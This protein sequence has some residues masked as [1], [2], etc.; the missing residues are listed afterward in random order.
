MSRVKPFTVEGERV[1]T[2]QVAA[3]LSVVVVV[4]MTTAVMA[5]DGGEEYDSFMVHSVVSNRSRSLGMRV[6]S[7]VL[8]S[9][10]DRGDFVGSLVGDLDGELLLESENELDGIEAVEAEVFVEVRGVGD[11]GGVDLVELFDDLDHALGDLLRRERGRGAEEPVARSADGRERRSESR[12]RRARGEANEADERHGSGGEVKARELRQQPHQQQ[13]AHAK[14]VHTRASKRASAWVRVCEIE[15]VS[16]SSS[17]V[18]ARAHDT[19]E[20]E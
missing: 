18:H 7:K 2:E 19:R 9:L 10:R 4:V 15:W 1:D 17:S 20:G 14:N 12:N 11:L 13:H 8:N 16:P 6:S 3:L 5:V